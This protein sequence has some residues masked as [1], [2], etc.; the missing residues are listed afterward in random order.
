MRSTSVG[1]RRGAGLVVLLTAF[2]ST[3]P[4]AADTTGLP[5]LRLGSNA[6]VSALGEAGTALLDG[7]AF[8]TNPA[9]L[10]LSS[11]RVFGVTHS[12]WIQQIRHEYVNAAWKRPAG[13][14]GLAVLVSH[15]DELERRVQPSVNPLG[16]FGVSE[17]A[18]G[19]TANRELTSQLRAGATARFVRQS[20]FTETAA[21]GAVDIGL[22][23]TASPA[24][25][26][27]AALNNLGTLSS[28][29]REGTDLPLQL[30]IGNVV[31]RSDWLVSTDAQWARGSGGS[32]HL[33]MEWAP[34]P[35][36]ALRTGYQTSDTRRFSFGTGVAADGWHLDYTFVPFRD[37]LGDAHRL[38]LHRRG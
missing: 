30:K 20:V 12:E 28:L 37:D 26:L 5:F 9:A 4:L 33:G 8:A 19:I 14:I 34:H 22:L 29:D 3:L 2:F 25:M 27:G 16:T 18:A 32:L 24:W 1:A 15:V 11:A 7:Q 38:S 36:F 13:A 17:W 31:T 10:S 35:G 21:G 6:R 23:Y